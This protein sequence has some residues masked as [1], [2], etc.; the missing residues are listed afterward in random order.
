MGSKK[1]LQ[2]CR[3][4]KDHMAHRGIVMLLKRSRVSVKTRKTQGMKLKTKAR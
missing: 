3:T 2:K 4:E 1:C